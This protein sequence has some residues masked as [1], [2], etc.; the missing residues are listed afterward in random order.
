MKE[1]EYV[2]S[3][4]FSIAYTCN[5]SGEHDVVEIPG[6][7]THVDFPIPPPVVAFHERIERFARFV[8]LDKRGTGASDRV[9]PEHIPT[10]EERV[11]DVLAVLRAVGS[12]HVTLVGISEG[13]PMA[14][15]LAATHPEL[16]TG[17]VLYGSYPVLTWEEHGGRTFADTLADFDDFLLH[18][19]GRA[20]LFEAVAP[21]LVGNEGAARAMERLYRMAASPHTALAIHRMA[22]DTDVSGILATVS[23]PAVV[24]HR[25]GDRRVPARLGRALADGI[26][27][28]R[29]IE[30]P[31]EDHFLA[32]L[33]V[34]GDEIDRMVT[35]REPVADPERVL[36][37]VLFT[38]IE[39][40]TERAVALGDHAWRG[41]LDRHDRN[42]RALV[43]G[44]RGRWIK[45]TGDG[46]L[47][48]FDGPARAVRCATALHTAAADLGLRIRAGLHAGEIESGATTSAGSPC[49]SRPGSQ[50]WRRRVRH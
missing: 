12:K 48:T 7:A 24:I 4:G 26:P 15:L 11:D 40:S 34:I 20:S 3:G 42:A 16:V 47:A 21:S 41:L 8:Q 36:A 43:E 2:E 27:N 6:F 18:N 22:L 10:L 31:G 44:H 9:D 38:D 5:G 39:S 25:R 49:T 19:W 29:Y 50:R 28:A 14:V 32:P 46:V 30:C 13:G 37:T 45:S 35:G 23:V 17:L 33:D 1:I